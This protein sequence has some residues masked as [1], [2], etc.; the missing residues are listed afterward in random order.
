MTDGVCVRLSL[1]PEAGWG[2]FTM[3]RFKKGALIAVLTGPIVHRA[4]LSARSV[5]YAV[6]WDQQFAIDTLNGDGDGHY[7][8]SPA[9]DPHGRTANAE[10]C[11][12]RLN[13]RINLRAKRSI[14]AY[15]EVLVNYG[16]ERTK[17]MRLK[18]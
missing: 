1:N 11:T 7:A 9:G 4:S 14:P 2:L 12:D 18:T 10:F 6:H 16:A 3:R 5:D 17:R 15:K 13:K 8:N